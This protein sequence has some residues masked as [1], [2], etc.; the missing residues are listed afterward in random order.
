MVLRK[1]QNDNVPHIHDTIDP[2]RDLEEIEVI[3]MLSDL[4]MV[5]K[6]I[7]R[8][9]QM[10]KRPGKQDERDRNEAELAVLEKIQPAL[11]EGKKI[12][13][14]DLN[15]EEEKLCRG[16]QFLTLKP[17]LAVLNIDENQDE[18]DPAFDAIKAKAQSC[19]FIRGQMQKEIGELD[20]ADRQVFLEE[21]GIDNSAKDKLIS[22][23]YEMLGLRTFITAGDTD[24]RAWTITG[25][26]TALTA[27]GKIHSDIAKGFIRAEVIH[28]ADFIA[29]DSSLKAA[30]AKNL[31]HLEGKDYVVQ[32]GD[33]INIRF[34][35]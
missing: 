4:D 33:I 8:I 1:F 7:E 18:N 24:C 16:F 10:L 19:I 27:A 31:E 34:N 14:L 26:D 30:K 17:H 25:G 35:T 15:P 22:S 13:D 6:R 23:C 12:T 5:E 11:S 21:M 20:E 28:Y 3:A 29:C 32:D 2:L 9:N